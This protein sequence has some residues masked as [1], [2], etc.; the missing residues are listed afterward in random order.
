VSLSCI[1][2]GSLALLGV[3]LGVSGVSYQVG[4]MCYISYPDSKGSFW[5]PLIAVSFLSFLIQIF[6]MGYCIRGVITRGGTARISLFRRSDASD[7]PRGVSV[8]TRHVSRKIRQILALQWRAIAIACLI[9]AYVVYVAVAVLR[10]GDRAQYDDEDLLPWMD[11]LVAT[12]DK[13]QCMH[14]AKKIGV[15]QATALSALA[16][17]A[18]PLPPPLF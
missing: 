1:F 9:L 17:L 10:W 6:I 16:L 14:H 11:C 12:Q 18:V 5:G 4:D 15:N 8:P 2:F 3:A 13:K 7:L